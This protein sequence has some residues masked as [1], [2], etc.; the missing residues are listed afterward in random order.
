MNTSNETDESNLGNT[1]LSNTRFLKQPAEIIHEPG[2]FD[3]GVIHEAAKLIG[4]SDAPE[5]AITGILRLISE[6]LGLNRGRVLLPSVT[7]DKLQ[8][9]YS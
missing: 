1:S 2:D 7:Q 3:L 4:N 5:L 6:F 9:R 8:I